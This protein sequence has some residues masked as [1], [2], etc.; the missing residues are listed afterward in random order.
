MSQRFASGVPQ[1]ADYFL[2][3][4]MGL[5]FVRLPFQLLRPALSVLRILVWFVAYTAIVNLIWVVVLEDLSLL[6]NTVFYLY[7]SLLFLTCL[8]LYSTWKEH[9][10]KVTVYAVGAS[11]I[12]QGLLLPI[13]PA[14]PFTRSPGFFNDENQL[15]YYCVLS[16]TIFVLGA[17][18]FSLPPWFQVLFYVTVGYLALLA[19][20]RS[21]LLALAFM[22]LICS[23]GRPVRLLLVLSACAAIYL[24]MTLDPELVGMVGDRLVTGGEYDSLSTR[25]YDRIVN[26]PEYVLFG[27]GEGAYDRFRS[28]LFAS[29]IHSSYGTLLF[30]YGI[31]GVLLFTAVLVLICKRAPTYTLFLLP[32]FVHGAAHQGLRFAYFWLMLGFLTCLALGEAS[33]EPAP[34]TSGLPEDGPLDGRITGPV[35]VM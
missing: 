20:S 6:K 1:V 25:G 16:A 31:V 29:E 4:F 11:V 27:A 7:D 19:Q 3:A 14:G 12:L 22:C 32:A 9:F 35:P 15:G 13:A 17:R 2:T 24:T 26:H 30:C 34:A 8:I 21:S 28:D 5:L 10:L 33:A 23:L 18:R